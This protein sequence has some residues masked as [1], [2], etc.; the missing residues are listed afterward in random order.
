MKSQFHDTVSKEVTRVIPGCLNISDDI[1]VYGKTQEE[2]DQSLEKLL[3]RA[4]KKKITF[5]KAKCEFN[6]ESCLCYGMAFSK[7]RVSPDPQKVEAT[8]AA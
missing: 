6:K 3:R 1:L 7:E 8:K 2:H 4:K 5:N